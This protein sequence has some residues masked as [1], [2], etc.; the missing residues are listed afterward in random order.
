MT[1]RPDGGWPS[2]SE[3][4][5]SDLALIAEENRKFRAALSKIAEKRNQGFTYDGPRSENY[6]KQDYRECPECRWNW[7]EGD[8]ERHRTD[9]GVAIAREALRSVRRGLPV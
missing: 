8:P 6:Q 7:R 1:N 4:L 3:A 9:C 5:A 2:E